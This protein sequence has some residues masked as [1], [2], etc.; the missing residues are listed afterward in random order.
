MESLNILKDDVAEVCRRVQNIEDLMNDFFSDEEACNQ[1]RNLFPL[2]NVQMNARRTPS[3]AIAHQSLI[4]LNTSY[5]SSVS[6]MLHNIYGPIAVELCWYLLNAATQ[7]YGQ[8]H[9]NFEQTPMFSCNQNDSYIIY[10]LQNV[11]QQ[12]LLPRSRALPKPLV[13]SA[14]TTIVPAGVPKVM[15]TSVQKRWNTPIK[16]TPVEKR[17]PVNVVITSSDQLPQNITT[18]STQQ[19]A[20]SLNIMKAPY[21]IKNYA[22]TQ[23]FGAALAYPTI[24]EELKQKFVD[25]TMPQPKR[26]DTPGSIGKEPK[27]NIVPSE[28]TVDSSYGKNDLF[29]V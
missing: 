6:Q 13:S 9:N 29:F 20:S 27:N 10:N 16:N 19:A 25:R 22:A 8:F 28:S 15:P 17:L 5:N 23:T 4:G 21:H 24:A 18:I 26:S 12:S 11:M 3:T 14:I 1:S 7:S 2:G